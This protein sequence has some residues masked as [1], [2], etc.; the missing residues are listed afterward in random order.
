MTDS[1]QKEMHEIPH[2]QNTQTSVRKLSLFDSIDN[3]SN[4]DENVNKS[5]E[6]KSEPIFEDQI[7]DQNPIETYEENEIES[8]DVEEENFNQENDE[9]LLDIPT[10]LRRQAN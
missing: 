8:S 3:Q 6:S 9:E 4:I 1:S 5:E 7:K 10:F 2:N